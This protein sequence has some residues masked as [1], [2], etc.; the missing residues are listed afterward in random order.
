MKA[1]KLQYFVSLLKMNFLVYL[2]LYFRRI[3]NT[4]IFAFVGFNLGQGLDKDYIRNIWLPCDHPSPD[5]EEDHL[6]P[7]ALPLAA[8]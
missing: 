3:L 8:G 7:D 4:H 6:L 2:F 1:K 5:E